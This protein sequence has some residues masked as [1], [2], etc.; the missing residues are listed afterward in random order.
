MAVNV[1]ESFRPELSMSRGGSFS[2]ISFGASNIRQ[3]HEELVSVLESMKN[4]FVVEALI[5]KFRALAEETLDATEEFASVEFFEGL[6]LPIEL[7]EAVEKLSREMCV[8]LSG[9][10]DVLVLKQRAEQVKEAFRQIAEVTNRT[11]ARTLAWEGLTILLK[12]PE[13][14]SLSFRDLDLIFEKIE[15]ESRTEEIINLLKNFLGEGLFTSLESRIEESEGDLFVLVYEIKNNKPKEGV[16]N[17]IFSLRDQREIYFRSET[18]KLEHGGSDTNI[19]EPIV[20]CEKKNAGKLHEDPQPVLDQSVA[21]TVENPIPNDDQDVR[22]DDVISLK[23]KTGKDERI[24]QGTWRASDVGVKKVWRDKVVNLPSRHR[25]SMS[26][27]GVSGTGSSLPEIPYENG[28][29]FLPDT[30][31]SEASFIKASPEVVC[32]PL[33]EKS[34]GGP[35]SHISFGASSDEGEDGES[36]CIV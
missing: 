36:C 21:K 15:S 3:N 14:Q 25:L 33:R 23:K 13:I 10:K 31:G 26:K 24:L 32:K 7:K 8:Y 5:A 9:A 4:P 20:A 18:L 29:D 16:V 1:N 34:K 19:Q 11:H 6:Y 35:S 12:Q 22:P 30:Q 27:G 2:E 17:D 28:P